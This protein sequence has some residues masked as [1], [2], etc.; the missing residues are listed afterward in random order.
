MQ[1]Y[2]AII[3]M[4]DRLSRKVNFVPSKTTDSAEDTARAFFKHVVPNHGLPDALMSDRDAKFTLKFW[5]ELL[6]LCG[7][8]LKMSSARYPQMD[9]S[10]EVMNRMVENFLCCYCQYKQN[11]WDLL[12]SAAEFTYNSARSEGLGVSPFEVDLGWRPRHS[13]DFLTGVRPKVRSVEDSQMQLKGA[14]EEAN[15]HMSS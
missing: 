3:T 14:F 9:G 11:Y 8:R 6:K 7:V 5:T 2:N 1:G 12:L 10:S 4:V 13:L 15:L